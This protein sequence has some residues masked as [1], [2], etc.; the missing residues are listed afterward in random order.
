MPE[1][2]GAYYDYTNMVRI[3]ADLEVNTLRQVVHRSHKLAQW[4]ITPE[5]GQ[6]NYN[7][8]VRRPWAARPAKAGKERWN[9]PADGPVPPGAP[10]SHGCPR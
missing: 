8:D 7:R 6:I 10:G 3:M 1:E 5:A 4:Q 2:K 9:R